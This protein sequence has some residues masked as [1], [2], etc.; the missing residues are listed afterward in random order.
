MMRRSG[1]VVAARHGE[2]VVRFE[3]AT[4][5][6]QCRARTVCGSGATTDLVLAAASCAG[7]VGDEV[8]VDIDAATAVR[9][10]AVAYL[11]PVLALAGGMGLGSALG[12]TEPGIAAFSFAGLGVG[13]IASRRL[14]R[15]PALH[16]APR[17]AATDFP[18]EE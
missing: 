2:L 15:H 14:G 17:L 1:R 6:G 7:R 3:G 16:P 12:L 10:L 4:A 18:S 11:L 13:L 5:C 9:A 8:M